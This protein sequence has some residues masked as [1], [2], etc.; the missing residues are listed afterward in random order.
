MEIKKFMKYVVPSVFAFALSGVYAIVD[1][2]FVGN[3]V[4]DAGITAINLVYP[5]VAFL[6]ALGTGIGMGGAIQYSIKRGS[7]RNEEANR[8]IGVTVTYLL[9]ASIGVMILFLP[10][11]DKILHILGTS[12][13]IADYGKTYLA[14]TIAGALCQIFGTGMTPMVRNNGGAAFSMYI[15]IAGFFTNVIFDY[16]LVWVFDKS[17]TGAA[18]ATV[19]GQ[20][21]TA[22][23]G[24]GYLMKK[25]LPL[26]RLRFDW[27]RFAHITKIGF[28]AFGVTLCPNISL[29][30]MNLFLMK[31]GGEPA[32]ACYAVISYVTYIVYLVLQGVGDGCQPLL[33]DYFGKGD[34]KSLKKIQSIS[35]F[36]AGSIAVLCFVLLYLTRGY[37]G[38]L[39][40]ASDLVC[41]LIADNLPIILVGFLFLAFARVITSAF[42]ATK[43]AGKA[44]LVV[45]S[46]VAFLLI[47]LL[48]LP[49]IFG[50]TAVWWS[51]SI[52]QIMAMVLAVI[53]KFA[54]R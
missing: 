31:Y 43:Q 44:I 46:E 30:L 50:E 36:T 13:L 21:V 1:G 33:S 37:I 18:V 12:G 19:M 41:E 32:I 39:F 52:A 42:Y 10:M 53:L 5:V 24:V 20:F 47:L 8:Y 35:Y 26:W 9:L 45:Y 16:L 54:A 51:M 22:L 2:Y 25:R 48:I 4:G 6:P 17:V 34:R 7:G 14:I 23:G 28:S 29:F 38:G 15:M 49:V 27:K 11:L 3:S 40:G